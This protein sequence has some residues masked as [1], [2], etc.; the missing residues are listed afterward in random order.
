MSQVDGTLATTCKVVGPTQRRP[1]QTVSKGMMTGFCCAK[2]FV[3]QQNIGD[4][5]LT[6]IYGEYSLAVYQ[7][8]V[9]VPGPQVASERNHGIASVVA[10]AMSWMYRTYT[11]ILATRGSVRKIACVAYPHT[12]RCDYNSSILTGIKTRLRNDLRNP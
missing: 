10:N 6:A 4:V 3:D 12:Q 1:S 9:G 8:Q 5:V 7:P 11:F 2:G